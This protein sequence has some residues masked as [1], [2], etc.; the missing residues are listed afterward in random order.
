MNQTRN[1]YYIA[2]QRIRVSAHLDDITDENIGACHEVIG[3]DGK[4][5]Y[6]VENSN[7]QVDDDGMVIEY[8]VRWSRQYGYTCTCACGK[9]GFGNVT[10]PSGVCW[11]VRA[12]VAASMEKDGAFT[13]IAQEQAATDT[14]WHDELLGPVVEQSK[15]EW[16]DE[17]NE[18]SYANG[19]RKYL[20]I[21]GGKE[22][23]DRTYARV[24]SAKPV[25]TRGALYSPKAFSILR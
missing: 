10:H 24:M 6:L 12:A 20:G 16:H 21:S 5:F 14:E 22:L 3:P 11:H 15:P 2:N 13:A 9:Y 8:E 23:D 19:T 25:S 7:Q 4:N 17:R 1:Q 18:T